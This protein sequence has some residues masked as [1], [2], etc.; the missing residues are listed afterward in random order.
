LRRTKEILEARKG[1]AAEVG[2]GKSITRTGTSE[3][4]DISAWKEI[5]APQL[6]DSEDDIAAVAYGGDYPS[7]E[8]GTEESS[9]DEGE[10]FGRNSAIIE[11]RETARLQR[12][13]EGVSKTVTSSVDTPV[14]LHRS[15]AATSTQKNDVSL[16]GPRKTSSPARTSS[17]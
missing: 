4:G 5:P 15:V 10:F 7:E 17:T 6:S 13:P 11:A 12:T 2:I 8:T 1:R 9:E 16:P 14:E 3:L